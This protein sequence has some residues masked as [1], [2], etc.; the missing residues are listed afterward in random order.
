[1][2]TDS[3]LRSSPLKR[4]LAIESAAADRKK[5]R[6]RNFCYTLHK[7]YSLSQARNVFVEEVRQ[8]PT[9]WDFARKVHSFIKFCRGVRIVVKF[10]HESF[11]SPSRPTFSLPENSLIYVSEHYRLQSLHYFRKNAYCT[12]LVYST[13]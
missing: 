1:M 12:L 11:L 5:L 8:Q 7:T 9:S 3:P 10:N 13:L 4:L 2:V 6:S